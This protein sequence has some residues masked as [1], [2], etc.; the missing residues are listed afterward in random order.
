VKLL[1]LAMVHR[2]VED[3][4][5]PKSSPQLRVQASAWLHTPE[6]HVWCRMAAS[7]PA[8]VRAAVRRRSAGA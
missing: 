6:C 8:D 2:A 7:G 3:A 4:T 1:A 5:D